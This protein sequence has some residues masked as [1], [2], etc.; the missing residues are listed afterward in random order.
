MPSAQKEGTKGQEIRGLW[1]Q[2]RDNMAT[3]TPYGRAYGRA[4]RAPVKAP[5][6]TSAR[7]ALRL[8][9]SAPRP[10]GAPPGQVELVS[11]NIAAKASQ[12]QPPHRQAEAHTRAR[13]GGS[14]SYASCINSERKSGGVLHME[15]GGGEGER[16]ALA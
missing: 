5:V 2:V 1:P 3:S 12:P 9:G 7:S 11:V 15:R 6:A 14:Q 10:T 8:G 4:L 13:T 16:P